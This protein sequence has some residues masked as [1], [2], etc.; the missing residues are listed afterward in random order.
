VR[1]H[2]QRESR[3][4]S[5]RASERARTLFLL[6]GRDLEAKGL[7]DDPADDER[8]H[9]GVGGHHDNG[10]RLYTELPGVTVDESIKA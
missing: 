3:W 2:R 6:L 5:R 10:Q 9:A 4:R 8:A 1:E 7:V